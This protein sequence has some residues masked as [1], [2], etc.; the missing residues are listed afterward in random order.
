M[1]VFLEF[2]SYR[3][4]ELWNYG[5]MELWSC[6]VMELWSYGEDAVIVLFPPFHYSTGFPPA[7]FVAADADNHSRLFQVSEAALDGG[8][9]NP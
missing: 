2:L 3:V 9:R 8:F 1:R 7:G 6:G 5:V 4:I